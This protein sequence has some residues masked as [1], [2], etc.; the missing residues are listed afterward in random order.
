MKKRNKKPLSCSLGAAA[1]EYLV[2]LCIIVSAAALGAQVLS[3]ALNSK[4]ESLF[5]PRYGA[6]AV[7]G[8]SPN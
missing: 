3:K 2:L 5:S 1:A 7:R 4:A 8:I 6:V